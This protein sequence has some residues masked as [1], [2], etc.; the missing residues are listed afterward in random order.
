MSEREGVLGEVAGLWQL[1]DFRR[2]LVARI[3]SNFGNGMAPIAL[4]FGVLSLKGADARSL[5]LV[6]A[7][8]LVPLVAFMLVGGV[9]ADR[10]D[11]AHLVGGTDI[12]GSLLVSVSAVAFLT[13]HASV[14]L[15]CVVGFVSGVLNAVWYPAFTGLMPLIVPTPRLQSANAAVG[16]GSNVGFILGASVAGVIVGSAGAG[17]AILVDA[18]TFMVAGILV[19]GLRLP[20]PDSN[21]EG[22]SSMATQLREGWH[23]FASRRWLV[24]VT[25][26]FVFLQMS[27]EGF[28]GVMAPVQTKEALHGAR[29]MGVMMSGFG[30]GALAGTVMA[31]KLRPRRPLLLA[32]GVMPAIG[33]WMFAL[34]FPAPLWVLVLAAMAAGAALDL[35]YAFWTTTIQSNVPDDVLSRVNSYD[36]FGALVFAPIGLLLAGPFTRAVGASTALVVAGSIAIVAALAPLLSSDVRRLERTS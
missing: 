16:I 5:S 31:M 27:L 26:C 19:Y 24:T 13:G 21:P 3:V 12:V 22:T 6:A 10:F 11:R 35:M 7:A 9:V 29:D 23:E 36:A 17:W 15:L 14:P 20:R 18:F 30:V 1:R 33:V 28:L 2:L 34:S 8:H 4:A 32:I 25:G